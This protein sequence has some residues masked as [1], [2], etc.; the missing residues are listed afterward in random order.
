MPCVSNKNYMYVS[1][2]R[3]V[4]A[5]E[6]SVLDRRNLLLKEGVGSDIYFHT[7][8]D[9]LLDRYKNDIT[10]ISEIDFCTYD[11]VNHKLFILDS[12]NNSDIIGYNGDNYYCLDVS[13]DNALPI[14][15]KN[16]V[17]GYKLSLNDKMDYSKKGY[18]INSIHLN[19]LLTN[20]AIEPLIKHI[21]IYEL[22]DGNYKKIP[23]EK[24]L[25]DIKVLKYTKKNW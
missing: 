10:E 12:I 6:Y 17:E 4:L 2:D 21:N 23:L 24:H 8:D 3:S 1:G 15:I 13:S 5:K 25:N 18:I 7:T 9:D 19:K 16:N 14:Y 22:S 11:I 20:N